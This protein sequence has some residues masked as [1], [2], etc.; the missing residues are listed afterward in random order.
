M[1]SRLLCPRYHD[2]WMT[3]QE[4]PEADGRYL[5]VDMLPGFDV[6]W[7]ALDYEHEQK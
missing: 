7:L 5:E 1:I 4:G 6:N 2:K 3:L